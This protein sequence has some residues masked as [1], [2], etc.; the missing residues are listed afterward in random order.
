MRS[1][2]PW[3]S[4]RKAELGGDDGGL[5]TWLARSI[6]NSGWE[7]K[8][9]ERIATSCKESQDCKD[10]DEQKISHHEMWT[11]EFQNDELPQLRN[12]LRHLTRGFLGCLAAEE[13]SNHPQDPKS[14]TDMDRRFIS[15][16]GSHTMLWKTKHQH[17]RNLK[18]GHGGTYLGLH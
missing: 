2:M 3:R 5:D 6:C 17:L 14:G 18:G 15:I 16:E 13:A 12:A 4:W 7:Q 8:G 10:Q 9:F 1:C 11:K